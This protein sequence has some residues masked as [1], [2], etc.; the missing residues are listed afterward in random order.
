LSTPRKRP[1]KTSEIVTV[2]RIETHL[3]RGF[4]PIRNLTPQRLSQALD[5]FDAGY[6]A[7]GALLMDKILRRDDMALANSQKRWKSVPRYDWEITQSGKT[8][9]AERQKEAAEFFFSRLTATSATDSNERG[10]VKL[11][12]R[13]MMTAI[14]FEYAAHEIVWRP[15]PEGLSAEFRFV[16]LWFF[17]HIGS[18]LRYLD[19]EGAAR[20]IALEDGEWMVTKGIALGVPTA[21]AYMFKHYPMHFWSIYCERYVIPGLH[22]KVEGAKGSDEWN[23]MVSALRAFSVDWALVT[24]KNAEVMPIDRGGSQGAAP[25][26]ALVERQDKAISTIWRGGDVASMSAGD[27]IGA[28]SQGEEK[29]LLEKD[30]AE[31]LEGTINTQVLPWVIWYALGTR[32]VQVEFRIS[33][34]ARRD[35]K[36]SIETDRFLLDAGVPI[37]KADLAERYGRALPDADETRPEDLATAPVRPPAYPM[38]NA[39]S[40]AAQALQSRDDAAA[41]ALLE[42]G[43]DVAIAAERA[44]MKPLAERLYAILDLAGEDDALFRAAVAQLRRDLPALAAEL[45]AAPA[46]ADALES[47]I[48][49]ALINGI[50]AGVAERGTA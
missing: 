34:P 31:I 44:D 19:F 26:A 21:I 1:A 10:N 5:M 15:T 18:D 48:G 30:D 14:G 9:E 46:L 47:V 33:V 41:E 43:I 37:A 29:D 36:A 42:R 11:L 3:S 25:F 4:N 7:A 2:P 27:S 12:L 28:E 45:A 20:G 13:Q 22:G 6:L 38:P 39:R 16:P 40:A 8:P 50:A 49:P 17:E 32:D 35:I 24:N 23:A